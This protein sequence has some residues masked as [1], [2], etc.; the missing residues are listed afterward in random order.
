MADLNNILKI[1]TNNIQPSKGKIL[2]SEPFLNDYYFKRSVVLLAEHNEE[3][4]FGLILNKPV[5]MFLHEMIKGFPEFNARVYLGGPVKT[6]NLYFIH[7]QGNLIENSMEILD[8]LYWGGEIEHVKELI[9]IGKL[10]PN[11]IKFY[12]GYAGWVTNQLEGE[13]ERNSW[14]VAN[15]RPSQ[16]MASNTQKLWDKSLSKLGGDY[17]YWINFP[18]DPNLN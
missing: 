6:D 1:R 9:M 5:D 17:S 15:I 7:T 10:Q 13:L 11:Q 16:V 14:L 8:G 3:G 2:I 12:V 18:S 4:S